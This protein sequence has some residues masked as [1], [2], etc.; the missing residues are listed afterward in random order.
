MT[1]SLPIEVSFAQAMTN[2][3]CLVAGL[4]L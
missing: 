3:G 2:Y 4:T 1:T